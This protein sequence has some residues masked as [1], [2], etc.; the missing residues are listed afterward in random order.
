MKKRK[1]I[2]KSFA[3]VGV[4]CIFLAANGWSKDDSLSELA[5]PYL[6]EYTCESIYF[7][8]ED[9]LADFDYF[10]LEI[11][12][13]GEMKLHIKEKARKGKTVVLSYEYDE[14]KKEFLVKSNFAL[15]KKEERVIFQDGKL[16]AV[17]RL[18]GKQILV[19]FS[20]K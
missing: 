19:K 5:C 2:I 13:Q 16:T 4:L 7:N 9:K 12:S 1:N 18:G 15:F 11:L 20:K 6:G 8:S 17:L 10:K 14:A 3:L